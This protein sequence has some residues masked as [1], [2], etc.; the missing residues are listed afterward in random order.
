[1]K[2]HLLIFVFMLSF[3]LFGIAQWSSDPSLNNSIANASGEEA[4]PK[5]ATTESGTTYICW[6]SSE[7]GNYN[8][9]LQKLD[10]YG[11]KQWAE[12]GLLI[13][14]NPAMS[15]LTEWDMTV[16]GEDH[17]VICFQDVRNGGYNNIYAYRISPE[18]EFIWGDDGLELSNSTAFD[19]AP[20]VVVTS[21]GN[22]VIAWQSDDVIIMQKISPDGTLLWGANGITL[23]GDNRFSWPQLLPVDDD[24]VIM[25]FYDDSGS[26]T[27]PTRLVY[28]QR[29]DAD[30]AEVWPEDAVISDAT[31]ISGWTQIL[32]FINDGNDGFYIAWHDDR[33]N[34]NLASIFVQHIGS[35][36]QVLF[37]DNGIEVSTMPN[38][39]HFY[40]ELA[41]PTGSDDIFVYWNEMDGNQSNWG[42]YGQK[43][44]SAGERLWTDNGIAFIEISSTNVS[45]VAARNSE[46]DMIVIFEEFSNVMNSGIKAMRIDTDGNF[47]Y[48]NDFVDLCTVQSEKVHPVVNNYL[49]GQWIATWEDNRN[50]GKDIYAQNIQLDGTLGPI[51]I[52]GG[53]LI[54]LP[55]T[56]FFDYQNPY[57]IQPVTLYNI[58]NDSIHINYIDELGM[59]EPWYRLTYLQFPYILQVGDS[60]ELEIAVPQSDIVTEDY[61]YYDMNIYMED[62]TS[63]LIIAVVQGWVGLEEF[64]NHLNRVLV[65][66]N[67]TTEVV[68]FE[69]CSGQ[70]LDIQV[71]IYSSIGK[72]IRNLKIKHQNHKTEKLTWNCTNNLNQKVPPGTYYYKIISDEFKESGKIILLK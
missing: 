8:V 63:K 22:A 24:D 49:N 14:D 66:P 43:I 31:G 46:S 59:G 16:D 5:I 71:G 26:M 25:K 48:E 51:S 27:Y 3:S 56:L 13:S 19:V 37:A 58:G 33:D 69:I 18:G 30:G 23:S 21:A 9:R 10:V 61:D 67:P 57:T 6:F 41:L 32:P 70:N 42:I 35:D 29:Y 60:L 55:D 52:S 47:V 7:S 38:R 44:S 40:A 2:A 54:I 68:Y 45:P 20:K 53:I 4:I 36:G 62:D 11:N 39:N 64:N 17:A 72:E 34:N 65:Y 28:A 12:E 50:G 1:M 15:W